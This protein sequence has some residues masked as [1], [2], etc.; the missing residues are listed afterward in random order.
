M[1]FLATLEE[2]KSRLKMIL[3][4]LPH[5]RLDYTVTEPN[6]SQFKIFGIYSRDT[7]KASFTI[8]LTPGTTKLFVARD[9]QFLFNKIT[10]NFQHCTTT[11]FHYSSPFEYYTTQTIF[12]NLVQIHFRSTDT[13]LQPSAPSFPPPAH[14]S[15][16]ILAHLLQPQYTPPRPRPPRPSPHTPRTHFVPLVSHLPLNLQ[17]PQLPSQRDTSPPVRDIIEV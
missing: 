2:I 9:L 15:Q 17:T 10:H 8:D 4:P 1:D 3:T 5:I 6:P 7:D 11:I 16:S 13:V 14:T 12:Y